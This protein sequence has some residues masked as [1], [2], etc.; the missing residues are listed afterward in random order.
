MSQLNV[1]PMVKVWDLPVRLFHWS[2]VGLFVFLIISGDLGDDLIEWHFYAGYLLS[3]LIVF[4]LVWGLVGSHHARFV[5]FIRNP[6]HTLRYSLNVA[7]GKA[8]HYEGHNPLGALMVVALLGLLAVQVASGLITT[9]DV[10][11]DGP[12]YSAVNE[13]MAELGGI[14]HHYVQLVLKVLVGLHLLAIVV[15]KVAFKE[16]LVPAMLHGRKPHHP[17]AVE[18]GAVNPVALVAAAVLAAGWVYYLFSLPL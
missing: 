6:L 15:H 16:A 8:G 1:K 9:D 18:T 10:I 12:F 7:R 11:W 4:R 2:L 5:N 17:A 3:G 14:T 13:E